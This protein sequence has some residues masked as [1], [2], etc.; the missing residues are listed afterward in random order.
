GLTGLP[1]MPMFFLGGC[2]LT[3]MWMASRTN[4]QEDEDETETQPAEESAGESVAGEHSL[5]D[6]LRVDPME[7]EV[8]VGLIRLADPA[9]GGDLLERIQLV[10]NSI[11]GEL[12]F[13]LPKVRIRDNVRL[14]RR[15]YRIKIAD[16]AVAQGAVRP[17]R[18]LAIDWGGATGEIAGDP[19]VEP[20]FEMPAAWI[21][22][23]DREQAERMGYAVA[24]PVSV[25]TT[26]LT[27][28]IRRHA[29]ELLT[30]D[31][32]REL[33]DRLKQASPSVVEE[34]V[35][36]RLSLG[37]VHRVLQRLLSEGVSIRNL[38]AILE[39]LGDRA[40]ESETAVSIDALAEAA[41]RKLSRSICR[42]HCDDQLRL[43]AVTLD[44]SW[45]ERLAAGM[46]RDEHGATAPWPVAQRE[47]LLDALGRGI[48]RLTAS[49]RPAAAVVDS[50]IRWAIRQAAAAR[51]PRLAVLCYEEIAA[52]VQV[53]S[54]VMLT[55][56]DHRLDA[57][58]DDPRE[59]QLAARGPS[60]DVG[61]TGISE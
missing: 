7:L 22:S 61:A 11:A 42:R 55:E 49:G 45:E 23:A 30:R 54:A 27:E 46:E 13:V 18:L 28:I 20:A 48:D 59:N 34:T 3:L 16:E 56:E 19:A 21:E 12:G 1:A 2:C 57:S 39:S 53:E 25:V 5:E 52:D 4:Q 31:A 8:G 47:R 9:R 38:A 14:D 6:A 10:R 35:P 50:R 15:Q 43:H 51:A 60:D 24:D 44:P 29:E 32:V 36:K 26:H 40:A 37:R 17:N 41:R 58:A 33:I